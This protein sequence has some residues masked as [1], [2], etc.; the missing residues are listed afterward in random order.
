VDAW[1]AEWV[2]FIRALERRDV[3]AARQSLREH[4]E[5][6]RRRSIELLR[7]FGLLEEDPDP[8]SDIGA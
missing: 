7:Q 2:G 8:P 5:A 1:L 4:N 3:Q 6:A